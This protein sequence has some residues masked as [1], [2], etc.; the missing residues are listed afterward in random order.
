VTA[1]YF[2]VVAT[3]ILR[4][5]G[6]AERDTADSRKVAV[7]NEAFARKFFGSEDPL[8]KHFGPRP[9]MSREFEIAGVVRNARYFTHG[10]DQPTGQIYFVPEAQ[11]DYTRVAGALFLHDIGIVSRPAANVSATSVLQAMA[12]VDP[13]LP[14]ISI[15]TLR[16]QVASQFT[17][18]RLLARFASFFGILSL[19]LAS[20]GLYGMTAYNAGQRVREIGVRVALGA[21][22]G[23]IIALVLRGALGLVLLGLLIGF[24]LTLAAGRFLGNQL[25][26]MNPYSAGVT[27]A[28]VLALGVP[29]LVASVIPAFRASRVAPVESLRSE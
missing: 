4:G 23:D 1:G 15:R 16:E 17:Q 29:A 13:N 26:G 22:R 9:T 10:L 27:L 6:L 24:P 28:A 21:T 20:I 18:P 5:R 11:A 8:G 2:E 19:F 7:V 25:Y 3:P 14:V 12:S